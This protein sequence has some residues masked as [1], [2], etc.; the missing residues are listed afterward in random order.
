M[1]PTKINPYKVPSVGSG[2]VHIFVA[3]ESNRNKLSDIIYFDFLPP[4]EA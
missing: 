4:F 3:E 2:S 1:S